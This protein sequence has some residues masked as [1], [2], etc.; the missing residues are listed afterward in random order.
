MFTRY[1]KIVEFLR[2]RQELRSQ[3]YLLLNTI[4]KEEAV[5]LHPAVSKHLRKR[6]RPFLPTSP[7]FDGLLGFVSTI[8]FY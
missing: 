2:F 6:S 1:H 8:L 4:P 5:R 3:Y 7:A